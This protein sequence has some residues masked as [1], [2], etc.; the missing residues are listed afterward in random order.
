[1][2][3]FK[4]IADRV[5]RELSCS[6]HSMDHILRVYNLCSCLADSEEGVDREVLLVSALLHDIARAREDSDE[7]RSIRHEI[8]GSRMAAEI[9]EELGYSAGFIGKVRHCIETHRYR[10]GNTPLTIEAKILFDADKLDAIGA[11]GIA[12]SFML[13]GQFGEMLYQDVPLEEF[14]KENTLEKDIIKDMSRHSPN[15]EYELKLK[16][17]PQRLFT[18]KAMELA[19]ERIEFMES[20]FRL[21]GEEIKGLR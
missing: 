16:K 9:L 2:N 20:F 5:E 4:P 6:A 10:S 3:Q 14:R 18:V 13:A 12:R 1:M 15:L 17:I 7:T 21:L 8:Q 11:V 19:R